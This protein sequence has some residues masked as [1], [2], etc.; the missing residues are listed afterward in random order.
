MS[1]IFQ[2]ALIV[3]VVIEI[4]QVK[5]PQLHLPNPIKH[6][7]EWTVKQAI[8]PTDDLFKRNVWDAHNIAGEL[9]TL[10]SSF[11]VSACFLMY[12]LYIAAA[13]T[14]FF[15]DR[16]NFTSIYITSKK[17]GIIANKKG[18]KSYPPMYSVTQGLPGYL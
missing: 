11:S 16:A 8:V 2:L 6:L 1:K 4:L 17:N 7:E 5:C 14:M 3:I 10:Q 9:I 13:S 12:I 15:K 18:N